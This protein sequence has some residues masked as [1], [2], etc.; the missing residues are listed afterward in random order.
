M[1]VG[2]NL[3]RKIPTPKRNAH[4]YMTNCNTNNSIFHTAE[5]SEKEIVK[6]ISNFKDS[7]AGWDD[8]KPSI[9]KHV[10]KTV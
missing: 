2:T 9:I 6:I 7:S 1:N 5:V 4:E 10:K 3:A 8:I